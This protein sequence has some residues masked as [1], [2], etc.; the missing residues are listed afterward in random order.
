MKKYFVVVLLYSFTPH[1]ALSQDTLNFKTQRIQSFYNQYKGNDLP[2]I[3]SGTVS[4][5]K[6]ENGKLVP[7]YGANFEYFDTTSYFEHRAYL[8]NKVLETILSTYKEFETLV[9]GKK[10]FLMECSNAHGGKMTPHY[11]HQNGLSID[12]MSPL[13][14][15]G[16][17]HSDLDTLGIDHYW[18]A[19]NNDGKY[20]TDN[21]VTIDFNLIAQHV[22]L[23]E[24]NAY[25]Y[26]LKIAKVILKLELKDELFATEYGRKLAESEIYFAKNLPDNINELH[27]D[28]YH[29]DFTFF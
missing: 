4:N 16:K 15:D 9:P 2:S 3:S 17:P 26:G 28:H 25:K 1:A 18:M 19:F 6:L 29:I 21:S 11:T 5:G 27:D 7:Y 12:F 13:L 20:I 8:H 24:S 14:K 10:F 23:L 22:L